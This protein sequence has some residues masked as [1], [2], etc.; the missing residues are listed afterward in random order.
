MGVEL[1]DPNL[2]PGKINKLAESFIFSVA[3]R[4]SGFLAV[5]FLTSDGRRPDN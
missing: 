4:G 3:N 2:T 1:F 5:L